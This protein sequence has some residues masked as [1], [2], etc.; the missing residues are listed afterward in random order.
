MNRMIVTVV[1]VGCLIGLAG[2][3]FGTWA[4]ISNTNG[5]RERQFMI[6]AC[7]VMWVAGIAFLTLMFLVPVPW[8]FLLWIPYGI[9][10][11]FGIIFGNR[12]QQRIRKEEGGEE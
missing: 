4:S 1:A 5:P 7:A 8:R 11:P 12:S 2:G 9:L 3:I 6:R 10:L